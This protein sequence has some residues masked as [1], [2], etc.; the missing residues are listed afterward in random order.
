MA[1]QLGMDGTAVDAR[2]IPNINPDP[3]EATLD[4][5]V[6]LWREADGLHDEAEELT[7]E[8]RNKE[9]MSEDKLETAEDLIKDLVTVHPEW[10]AALDEGH[11]PRVRSWD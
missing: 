10:K 3:D 8:A 11:D 1:E 4:A 6:A 7:D 2:S 5:I 9:R